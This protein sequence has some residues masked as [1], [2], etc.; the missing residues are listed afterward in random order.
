[1]EIVII[2]G[3]NY[4]SLWRGGCEADGVVCVLLHA[5]LDC[6]SDTKNGVPTF[7]VIFVF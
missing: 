7:F 5:L 2:Y 6:Q 1:M 4:S 3:C